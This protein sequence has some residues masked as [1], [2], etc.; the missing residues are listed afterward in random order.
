MNLFFLFTASA[1]L[2]QPYCYATQCGPHCGQFR[3]LQS[4]KHNTSL[5]GNDD[6]VLRDRQ[7][8][9]INLEGA[10][11]R[12]YCLG[13]RLKGNASKT[14]RRDDLLSAKPTICNATVAFDDDVAIVPR[15]LFLDDKGNQIAS[16]K[17][18]YL[19]QASTGKIVQLT[20][21]EWPP[22][23]P[24]SDSAKIDHH[25]FAVVKLSQ[26]LS[27]GSRIGRDDIHI[28]K[29][30]S[31][32]PNVQIISNYGRIEGSSLNNFALTITNC[33]R[34]LFYKAK[35]QTSTNAAATDCD[36]GAGSSGSGAYFSVE[37]RPKMFGLVSGDVKIAPQGGSFNP[38]TLST[39]VTQ[40]DESLFEAYDRLNAKS[41]PQNSQPASPKRKK[42]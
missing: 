11:A 29:D 6:R 14:P 31:G 32:R 35:D 21:G 25:D 9:P 2:Y 16:P 22:L 7:N 17:N 8:T 30:R 34:F 10:Q 42:Q 28:A 24:G 41:A 36:T 39:I 15:H 23:E 40:F 19:E 4:L 3:E 1:S 20:S 5:I 26:K 27:I 13:S 37:S 12:V 33:S 38:G 18:C